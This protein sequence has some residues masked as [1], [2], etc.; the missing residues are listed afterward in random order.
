MIASGSGPASAG[1]IAI[2]VCGCVGFVALCAYIVYRSV[3]RDDTRKACW[4]LPAVETDD[5]VRVL[6]SR[7]TLPGRSSVFEISILCCMYGLPEARCKLSQRIAGFCTLQ[8]LSSSKLFRMMH[9][10]WFCQ[11]AG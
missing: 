2:F 3:H 11:V 8:L 5:Q 6:P 7:A 10:R 1:G 9:A 4:V